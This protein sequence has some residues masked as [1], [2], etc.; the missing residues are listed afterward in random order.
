M[1]EWKTKMKKAAKFEFPYQYE[2]IFGCLCLLSMVMFRARS[3]P[4]EPY[5]LYPYFI[6]YFEDGFLAKGLI[7]T[8]VTTVFG[9]LSEKTFYILYGCILAVVLGF[10][11]FF[12]GEVVR[13]RKKENELIMVYLGSICC[14]A[15][16]SVT[17]FTGM[18]MFGNQEVFLVFCFLI[19]MFCLYKKK[20]YPL[21]PVVTVL[22]ILIDERYML[23]YL[24]AVL[25]LWYYQLQKETK[26]GV[27]KLFY[28]TGIGALLLSVVLRFFL[29]SSQKDAILFYKGLT[30]RTSIN[31]VWDEVS[32]KK[33][34]CAVSTDYFA[35]IKE[36][37]KYRSMTQ[38][39][40]EIFAVS[41]ALCIPLAVFLVWMWSQYIKNSTKKGLAALFPCCACLIIP[42][43]IFGS[44]YGW[45][46]VRL[47]FVQL[48][49]IFALI[50]MQ[51]SAMLAVV[52]SLKG[53]L[54]KVPWLFWLLPVYLL[55]LGDIDGQGMTIAFLI[56]EVF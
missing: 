48:L 32:L 19:S 6:S 20:A 40:Y 27:R 11:L 29:K 49:T 26:T 17:V 21:Q 55:L 5:N 34:L 56:Q 50:G 52:E 14:L 36:W 8:I 9:N 43:F 12:L 13:S 25:V 31:L 45:N 3:L 18:E 54:K 30:E 38:T 53:K 46:L 42:L 4:L 22:A 44:D 1:S 37:F 28:G 16:C 23:V 51:D 24:P 41:L 10:F 39:D 33:A 2:I 15:P 35:G 7:G 47:L